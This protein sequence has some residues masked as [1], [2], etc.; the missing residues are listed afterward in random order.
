MAQE[1]M[2]LAP[3][4]RGDACLGGAVGPPSGPPTP[5]ARVMQIPLD[6]GSHGSGQRLE[7]GVE[8]LK[9]YR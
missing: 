7:L 9:V 6:L 5:A 2:P 4:A 1:S 8:V 3:P